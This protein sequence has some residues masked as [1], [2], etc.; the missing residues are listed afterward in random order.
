MTGVGVVYTVFTQLCVS[1]VPPPGVA[2]RHV[3]VHVVALTH[4]LLWH[5]LLFVQRQAPGAVNCAGPPGAASCAAS[6]GTSWS[7]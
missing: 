2:D 4:W 5:W 3:P 6:H 7:G 1:S